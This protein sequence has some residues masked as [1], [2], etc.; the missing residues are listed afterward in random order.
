MLTQVF[1]PT[2]SI[3]NYVNLIDYH[4]M[5]LFLLPVRSDRMMSLK[6]VKVKLSFFLRQFS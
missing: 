2:E 5:I 4:A 3:E 1:K 6:S